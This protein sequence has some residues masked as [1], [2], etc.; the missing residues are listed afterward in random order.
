MPNDP[1]ARPSS[2]GPAFEAFVRSEIERLRLLPSPQ[3][4][5]LADLIE[6][7]AL[8]PA[9]ISVAPHPWVS[10]TLTGPVTLKLEAPAP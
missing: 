10:L 4:G 1:N 6:A 7:T 3:A 5:A 8:R 2:S 9:T